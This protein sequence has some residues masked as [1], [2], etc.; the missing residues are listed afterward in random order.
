M[1]SAAGA[2]RYC[3]AMHAAGAVY[4]WG[5]DGQIITGELISSLKKKFGALYY[6]DIDVKEVEGR[7]GADCSGFLTAMSGMDTTAAGYYENCKVKGMAAELPAD[8]VCLLFRS[9]NGRIV[10]VAVYTGDGTLTEMWNGCER[11]EFKPSQWTYYGVPDW[12]EQQTDKPLAA[13][14]TVTVSKELTGHHTAADAVA[15]KNVRSRVMPGTYHV[16]KVCGKATNIT[17]TKGV[18]GSWVVL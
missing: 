7:P 4:V 18:P 9:E 10:H 11:R 1:I 12:I 8:K 13:G 5:A 2:K 17:K 16:Y 6:E 15:G 3:A 14:D